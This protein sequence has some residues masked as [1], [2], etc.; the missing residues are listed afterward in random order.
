MRCVLPA[1]SSKACGAVQWA[2]VRVLSVMLWDF[3][4][5]DTVGTGTI[6]SAY[7]VPAVALPAQLAAAATQNERL[8]KRLL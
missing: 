4:T 3:H 7:T 1:V 6:A 5:S 2:H 8:L